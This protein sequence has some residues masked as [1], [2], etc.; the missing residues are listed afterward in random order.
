MVAS[1][2]LGKTFKKIQIGL[3]FSYSNIFFFSFSYPKPI[4]VEQL[5][6]K[7]DEDGLPEKSII[8]NS[9]Y[10]SEREIQPHFAQ[11]NSFELKL[12][13][14]WRELYEYEKQLNEETRKRIEQKR[15][16]LEYEIEQSLIDHKAMKL[17]EDLRAKQEELQRIEDMR[18]TDFQRRQ[19]MELR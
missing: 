14:K 15:E 17:K 5:D 18:K 8:K 11:N 6:T 1:Y 13:Y 7:D 12:A 19:D 3:S 2:L 16:M 10:Y 9:Q 4:V